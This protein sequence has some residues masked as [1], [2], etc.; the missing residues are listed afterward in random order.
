MTPTRARVKRQVD[1]DR[2]LILRLTSRPSVT[3]SDIAREARCS[4]TFVSACAHGRSRATPRVRE[5][6]ERLLGVPA[7][8][9]FPAWPRS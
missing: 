8:E 5:A 1:D 3:L 2:S 7:D 9:L 4:P 6:A